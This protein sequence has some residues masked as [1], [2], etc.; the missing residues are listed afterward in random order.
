MVRSASHPTVF[1]VKES[2]LLIIGLVFGVTILASV[3]FVL[4]IKLGYIPVELTADNLMTYCILPAQAVSLMAVLFLI[5][6]RLKKTGASWGDVG[7][8]RS[9]FK[10]SVL[11]ILA[12]YGALIALVVGVAIVA[13][14][15]GTSMDSGAKDSVRHAD[16]AI[17]GGFWIHIAVS[18]IIGPIIE[19]I[20]FRGVLFPALSQ[21]YKP[22][23]SILITA[24]IFAAAHIDPTRIILILPLGAYLGYMRYK[25]GGI[26]PGILLHMS[27]N[28]LA[29]IV[30]TA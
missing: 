15:T 3:L 5:R 8:R 1:S 18:V 20:L 11:Y 29:T 7:F 30:L 2:L 6:K 14:A 9:S 22:F 12:Y 17:A 13:V 10:K 21:K 19:E 4:L 28:L 27:W 16:N 25:L 26:Y 24:L 23:P